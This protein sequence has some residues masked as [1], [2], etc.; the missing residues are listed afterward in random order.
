MAVKRD[1][2]WLFQLLGP[3]DGCTETLL[4]SSSR[5]LSYPVRVDTVR[6]FQTISH[7]RRLWM[8]QGIPKIEMPENEPVLSYAPG[9]AEKRKLKAELARLAK[10][11]IDIPCIIGGRSVRTGKLAKC[12]MPHDHGH[13]LGTYHKAGKKEVEFAVAAAARA[14]GE[15]S[16]MPWQ[17]RAAVFLKA[18]D[19]LAGEYR[20]TINAA[21]M[22]C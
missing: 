10:R 14:K 16:R 22:L 19:L 9:S 11:K 12:V 1:R 2:W 7:N 3:V 17:A 20:Q 18:A 21:T 15:W 6:G 5:T 8:I 13:V 4:A